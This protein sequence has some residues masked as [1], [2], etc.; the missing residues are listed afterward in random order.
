MAEFLDGVKEARREIRKFKLDLAHDFDQALEF[1]RRARQYER[2]L[3]GRLSP[4]LFRNLVFS[5]ANQ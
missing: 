4:G 5:G 2:A 3:V 1:T